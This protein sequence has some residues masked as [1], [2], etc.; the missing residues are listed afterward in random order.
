MSDFEID[1]S[2][3]GEVAVFGPKGSLNTRTSPILEQR[4]RALLDAKSRLIVV[5]MK[6][7]DY[8]SSSAL[9]VLLMAARRL[10]RVSGKLFLCGLR[11]EVRKV[12]AISGFDRDF[13]IQANRKE[14]IAL[15]TATALPPL[16]ETKSKT[17]NKT[18]AAAAGAS[19]SPSAVPAPKAVATAA[20]PEPA[21]APSRPPE[22][23]TQPAAILALKLLS[24]DEDGPPWRN[25]TG[26]K[27]SERWRDRVLEALAK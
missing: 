24:K 15:G 14:A 10:K 9:R 6:D 7:V 23:A 22:A 8:L 3:D 17:A 5:D 18:P 26:A 4:L 12:F 13:N 19:D 21:P 27:A 11:E 1:E 2:N 25:W 20:I 16:E